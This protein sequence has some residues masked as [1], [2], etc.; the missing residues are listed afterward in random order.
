MVVVQLLARVLTVT[1]RQP[2]VAQ[3]FEP[4]TR[5][6]FTPGKRISE[7]SFARYAAVADLFGVACGFA[8]ARL[9]QLFGWVPPAPLALADAYVGVLFA[10]FVLWG[11]WLLGLYRE[12]SGLLSVIELRNT[13]RALG[14]VVLAV[15][16]VVFF[17][18][19]LVGSRT[20][21]ACTLA[22]CS[23][24]V[25][26]ERR[27]VCAWSR[28]LQNSGRLGRRVLI[29][30]CTEA[31]QLAMKRIVHAPHLRRFVVG[32]VDDLVPRGTIMA[33]RASQL[34]PLLLESPVLGRPG[35]AQ[36]RC[37]DL[38]SACESSS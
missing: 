8:V 16:G 22:S 13:L 14:M 29:Y 21:V 34:S 4:E 9:V 12:R 10:G 37:G 31:G 11:F 3:G 33:C 15:S 27:I 19:D 5:P 7:K 36:R 6:S 24:F 20:S 2:H 25:V 23:L 28:H 17:L 18:N 30:G 32:F 1:V 38:R 26:L 35:T